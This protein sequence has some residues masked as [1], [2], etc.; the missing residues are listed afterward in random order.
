MTT[1]LIAL[2]VLLLL[3]LIVAIVAKFI[4]KSGDKNPAVAGD[5]VS[6]GVLM[7]P[8]EV[9]FYLVLRSSLPAETYLICPKV[10]LADIVTVRGG[11]D[12]SHSTSALNSIISKHVDFLLCKPSDTTLYAAIELDDASHR[13]K[14]QMEKDK[15]KDETFG[16]CGIPLIRFPVQ[17]TY[18]PAD[19]AAK[20][21]AAFGR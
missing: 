2:G 12:R 7:S 15:F 1:P 6:R 11:L 18:T 17:A 3:V 10:R 4:P 21:N 8:A 13:R 5:Y 14:K 9:S 20:I 19:V 16:A